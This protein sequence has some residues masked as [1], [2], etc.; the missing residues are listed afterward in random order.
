MKTPTPWKVDI[1]DEYESVEIDYFE[2]VG[3]SIPIAK[4]VNG[5]ELNKANAKHIVKCVNMH[6]GLTQLIESQNQTAKVLL[7]RIDMAIQA[8]ERISNH[9][10]ENVVKYIQ[11]VDNIAFD[12]LQE[13]KAVK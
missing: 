4:L 8:L 11:E 6:E 12:A 2:R 13:I 1:D 10:T 5:Y 3:R 7:K 9:G